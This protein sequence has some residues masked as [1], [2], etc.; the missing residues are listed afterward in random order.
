M[1]FQGEVYVISKRKTVWLSAPSTLNIA[2]ALIEKVYRIKILIIEFQK[3]LSGRC[4][5]FSGPFVRPYAALEKAGSKNN[6]QVQG[7]LLIG[8]SHFG[9]AGIH[10][11]RSVCPL[12]IQCGDLVNTNNNLVNLTAILVFS[13]SHNSGLHFTKRRLTLYIVPRKVSLVKRV[14]KSRAGTYRANRENCRCHPVALLGKIRLGHI[15]QVLVGFPAFCNLCSNPSVGTHYI[16][17]GFTSSFSCALYPAF[18]ICT[19]MR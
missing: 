2:A 11:S 4:A 16:S 12:I 18:T 5:G 1:L 10:H 7:H 14:V 8:K 9:T 19:E 3:L 15:G 6:I 17:H 13:G